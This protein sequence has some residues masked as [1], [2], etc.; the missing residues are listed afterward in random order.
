MSN[1]SKLYDADYYYQGCGGQPY[2]RNLRWLV[3][4]DLIAEKIVSEIG[5][6]S[7]LDAGCAKGFLVECLR[8]H[9]VEAFGIDISDYAI[10]Q[11]REDIKPYCLVSSITEPLL[12]HYDLILCIEVL[13]HL[14]QSDTD[15]AILNLCQASDDI[16]FSS[17]PLDYREVTHFNVQPPEYW[18]EK[19]ARQGFVRD[20]DFDAS[21]IT[22]WAARF[23]RNHEPWPRV[24]HDYER[25]FWLLKKENQELRSLVVELRNQL[26]VNRLP[27]PLRW[28]R[29]ALVPFGSWRERMLNLAMRLWRTRRRN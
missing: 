12:K 18:A 9:G 26:S 13:E 10:Q 25:C 23:R 20:V 2:E 15:Q 11:A 5:P 3:F 4:F 17:T 27:R 16:L 6:Q 24:V 7:V 1:S 28:L 21:F 8:E 22:P 19:F 14:P 29:L